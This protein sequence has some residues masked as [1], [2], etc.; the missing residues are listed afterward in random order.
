MPAAGDLGNWLAVPVETGFDR[1]GQG[2]LTDS[3]LQPFP[4][5]APSLR[6]Q[7]SWKRRSAYDAER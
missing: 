3:L 1:L 4:L 2:G 6:M 7:L 5:E